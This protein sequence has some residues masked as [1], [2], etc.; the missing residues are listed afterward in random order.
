ML[1]MTNVLLLFAVL[2]LFS[3][4]FLVFGKLFGDMDLWDDVHRA[5]GFEYS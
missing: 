3:E 5:F 1:R 4:F 2:E